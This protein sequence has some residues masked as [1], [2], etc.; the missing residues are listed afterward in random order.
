MVT[1]HN[2]LCRDLN[3][4][5]T[6]FIKLGSILL[7]LLL[8]FSQAVNAAPTVIHAGASAS[9]GQTKW[10]SS[11]G[12][13]SCHIDPPSDASFDG[14]AGGSGNEPNNPL[15]F[16]ARDPNNISTVVNTTAVS[17]DMGS[18]NVTLA[19]NNKED[20]SAYFATYITPQLDTI[21]NLTLNPGDSYPSTAANQVSPVTGQDYLVDSTTYDDN[22]TFPTGLG[23][24]STTGVISGTAPTLT[25]PFVGTITIRAKNVNN[26][27]RGTTAFTL[28]IR[29]VQNITFT[30]PSISQGGTAT[31][32]ATSSNS[33]GAAITFT[34]LTNSVCTVSG[35]TLTALAASNGLTCTVRASQAA[36]GNFLAGTTQSSVTVGPGVQ[37]INFG[38]TPTV[39]VGGTGT[40]S[41]T[42]GG[43]GN[44]VTF[45]SS[46][47]TQCTTSGTNGSTVT[48]VAAGTNNC[49]I[50]ADQAAGGGFNAAAQVSLTFSIGKA[51][52]TI[53]FGSAPTIVEGGTGLV[54]ATSSNTTGAALVFSSATPA[55]C[56]ISGTTVTSITTGTC[57]I[58]A[59][60][61]ADANNNAA[62]NSQNIT[63][64]SA[65]PTVASATFKVKLNTT[66][67]LDLSPFTTGSSITGIRITTAPQH[68]TATVSGEKIT[69]TPVEDF[70]GKDTIQFTAFGTLG[71]SSPATVTIEIDERPDPTK[72]QKV[73]GMMNSQ[74]DTTKRMARTQTGFLQLRTESLHNRFRGGSS[75][76]N[77]T[78]TGLAPS[79]GVPLSQAEKIDQI[80]KQLESQNKSQASTPSSVALAETPDG[81]AAV[82][83]VALL[84]GAG[85]INRPVTKL[86]PAEQT[87]AS[88]GNT[89]VAAL[90]S[91]SINL[92]G[93]SAKI[94][95][96]ASGENDPIEIWMMGNIRFG[97][98]DNNDGDVLSRFRTSGVTIG[99]DK[100]FTKNLILGV[101]IGYAR[102]KTD[103][104][105]DG[106]QSIA[107]GMS[108][109]LYASYMPY[110]N[111]F[112]DGAIGYGVTDF[113]SD[114]FVDSVGDFAKMSRTGKQYFGVL[115][116]SY[117]FKQDG[118]LFAPYMRLNLERN[119]L[120]SGTENGA[121]NNNLSF[122]EQTSTTGQVALGF[123]A[124]ATH[125]IDAGLAIPHARIEFQRSIDK[126]DTSSIRYADQLG[127]GAFNLSSTTNNSRGILLGFG[128]NFILNN[129]L[130]LSFEYQT[131]RGDG[132]DNS[133]SLFFRVAKDLGGPEYQQAA[134][135]SSDEA[136][137]KLG[138][139][140]DA[141]YTYDDNVSRSELSSDKER[142]SI[143]SLRLNKNFTFNT[144][145]HTRIVL[146][147]FLGGE[148]FDRFRGLEN[149][150][151]GLQGEFQY[152]PSGAFSAPT[153]GVL[154]KS[155]IEEYQSR[156]RDSN[157]YAAGITFRKPW[158]EKLNI[159]S[160]VTYNVRQ[161]NS[162]VF[163]TQDTSARVNF[164]YM[165]TKKSSV[166]LAGEYRF[167]D[168]L[169]A[170]SPSIKNA[171]MA[172]VLESDDVFTDKQLTQYRFKGK[173]Y[174]GTLGLNVPL[175]PR[176]AID[177][178]WRY[179][180]STPDDIPSYVDTDVKY[181]VNQFSLVY[182][183]RF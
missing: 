151:A 128:N 32:T 159:F 13:T 146:G 6:D 98:R 136:L 89:L 77:A 90:N 152:R 59:S 37:T 91:Q 8:F 114:R 1:T 172:D 14:S 58:Q 35:N 15:S 18:G 104:S 66:T 124:E 62:T 41:A 64:G 12:C 26:A 141:A 177:L 110:Q 100:K 131:L 48:G 180:Q 69:Y 78:L 111:W 9:S 19:T 5:A 63:I 156:L 106:S 168:T 96:D 29:A 24:G 162:E 176:D 44:P 3:T 154:V 33:G 169:S 40:V 118:L 71:E 132:E 139:R 23:I 130:R 142:D 47:P 165:I 27:T 54:S 173:T 171:D 120:D 160:S 113:D 134:I 73:M 76:S 127:G 38:S 147:G 182:L 81:N 155:S 149:I 52:P 181:K 11:L 65:P 161:S 7:T 60:Q 175:G 68:G 51:S 164:D 163:D 112:L 87:L 30:A 85:S 174:M 116:T 126:N 36:S 97:A 170:G 45:S 137:T 153:Y 135:A 125:K 123:R 16:Y 57:T 140:L 158:S 105:D 17:E 93:L 82:Q 2:F 67:V 107:R 49:T 43:S 84:G 21:N 117:E 70:F 144:S 25:S 31:L 145:E 157:R 34:S 94:G 92:A 119:K 22:N 74:T 80:S 109:S 79:R 108:G 121:G 88:I 53:T 4:R 61:A 83:A 179:I 72:N 42:G 28:T 56:S 122:S 10:S 50:L 101:G 39:L 115:S 133:Q 55:V 102:E 166:Y 99:M 20:L 129:G 167:G 150:S 103:I 148:R 138:V 86:T 46:T 95:G 143:Y 75:S 178:S 183:V